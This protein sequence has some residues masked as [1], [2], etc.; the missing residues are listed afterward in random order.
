MV[1]GGA[2]GT[3]DII[4]GAG[5]GLGMLILVLTPLLVEPSDC[6]HGR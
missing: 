6:L 5:Y 4:R 3:E 1:S 2:Y